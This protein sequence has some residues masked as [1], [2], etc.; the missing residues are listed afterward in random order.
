MCPLSLRVH[1]ASQVKGPEMT[2]TH[3]SF[4]PDYKNR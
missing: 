2:L 3:L 1:D 4:F